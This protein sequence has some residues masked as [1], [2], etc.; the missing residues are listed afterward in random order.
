[1][2]LASILAAGVVLGA[3]VL[4]A[5]L[6]A[7]AVVRAGFAVGFLGAFAPAATAL[8]H[9]QTTPMVALAV[10]LAAA[11]ALAGRPVLSGALLGLGS[12]VKL[13]LLALGVL[14][15]MRGRMRAVAAFAAVLV[16]AVAASLAVFGPAL[17]RQYVDGLAMHAGT[18]MVGHNNQSLA[19]LA[20]R[21]FGPAPVY[22]WTPRAMGSAASAVAL[23]LTFVLGALV[24][25]GSSSPA[26][27]RAT[28]AP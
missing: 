23:A 3:L 17:Q 27:P 12:L 14:D 15:A 18:V 1:M 26:A 9:G 28:R 25:G 11:A 7:S 4:P 16:L 6:G 5:R 22:D 20:A 8:R 24:A 21:L 10:T 19:A 2:G 13:P